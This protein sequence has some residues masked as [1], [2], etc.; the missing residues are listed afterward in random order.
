[1]KTFLEAVNNGLEMSCDVGEHL[2][3]TL[4]GLTAAIDDMR[5]RTAAFLEKRKAYFTGR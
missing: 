1:M 4:F 5:E 2:E 3:A